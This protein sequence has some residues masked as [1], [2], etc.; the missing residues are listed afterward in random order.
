[1]RDARFHAPLLK[2]ASLLGEL[3]VRTANSGLAL[4]LVLLTSC[5][6][7]PG[8]GTV[9]DGSRGKSQVLSTHDAAQLAAKLAN[10]E[11]ERQFKRRPFAA[12][13]YEAVLKDGEYSWG[14]VDVGAPGGYS[15]VVRFKEDGSNPSVQVY[16]STDVR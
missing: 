12:E 6:H 4:I 2:I 10:D 14:R 5:S 7:G 15:A 9:T 1:M 16:L 8:T 3:L 11:G 13:Q